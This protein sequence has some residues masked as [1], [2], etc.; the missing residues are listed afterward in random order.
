MFSANPWPS[1]SHFSFFDENVNLNGHLVMV[2]MVNA[3]NGEL[4]AGVCLAG[5]FGYP[6]MMLFRRLRRVC[7]SVGGSVARA[8]KVS[9]KVDVFI[10]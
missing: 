4:F 7:W 10:V 8:V 2:T 9:N 6:P 3:A 5:R 1:L